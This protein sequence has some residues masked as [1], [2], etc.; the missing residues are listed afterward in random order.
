MSR[1][2]RLRRA[3]NQGKP[4]PEFSMGRPIAPMANTSP[5]RVNVQIEV[6][7][8]HLVIAFEKPCD[9]FI[10]PWQE[11]QVLADTIEMAADAIP[12]PRPIHTRL[13]LQQEYEESGLKVNELKGKYICFVFKWAGY[14]RLTQCAARSL[15]NE[16]RRR[17]QDLEFLNVKKVLLKYNAAGNCIPHWLWVGQR[18]VFKTN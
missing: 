6:E 14:I 16:I 17:G 4:A 8:D 12:N 2:S 18:V 11:M 7:D 3:A 15:I 1:S 9:H 13:E 5:A 10:G